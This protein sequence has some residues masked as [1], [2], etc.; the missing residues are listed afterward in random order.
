MQSDTLTNYNQDGLFFNVQITTT[1]K[2]RN[3]SEEHKAS[4]QIIK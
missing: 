4:K 2:K 3:K 1:G